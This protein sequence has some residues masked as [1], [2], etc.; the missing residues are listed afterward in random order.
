MT[1]PPNLP[2]APLRKLR[3]RRAV[4]VPSKF[5]KTS[6]RQPFPLYRTYAAFPFAA[7]RRKKK[8]Y[9]HS[10]IL[11]FVR[12]SGN[13]F[14]S[15]GISAAGG[16]IALETRK[17]GKSVTAGRGN[18][19]RIGAARG[20]RSEVCRAHGGMKRPAEPRKAGYKIRLRP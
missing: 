18:L 17:I 3:L 4:P 15:A 13:C 11:R 14:C 20:A 1:L 12:H 10:G 19:R 2:S 8:K 9:A 7:R 5:F 16:T 6:P